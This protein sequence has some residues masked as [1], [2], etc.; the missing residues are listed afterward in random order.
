[1]KDVAEAKVEKPKVGAMAD[2]M[3]A[4]RA[5]MDTTMKMNRMAL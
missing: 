4:L 3:S 1:M 2:E 5:L